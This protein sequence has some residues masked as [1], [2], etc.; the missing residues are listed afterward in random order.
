MVARTVT[1]IALVAAMALTANAA[2]TKHTKTTDRPRVSC[3]QIVET[4][5]VNKSVDETSDALLVDQS[6][7]VACLKAGG[8]AVPSEYDR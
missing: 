5:K 4:Y 6:V 2:G 7:V 3:K 8:V 1:A